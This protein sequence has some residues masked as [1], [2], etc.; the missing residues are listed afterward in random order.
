MS[1]INIAI[2]WEWYDAGPDIHGEVIQPSYALVRLIYEFVS[3]MDIPLN[4]LLGS[5]PVQRPLKRWTFEDAIVQ[6]QISHRN[7]MRE[8]KMQAAVKSLYY[9]DNKKYT[10]CVKFKKLANSRR[11]IMIAKLTII[12][13][14]T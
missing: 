7:L 5:L 9:M 12:T 3:R 4:R 2:Q 10:H 1:Y 8:V 11:H 6:R 13:T 14:T